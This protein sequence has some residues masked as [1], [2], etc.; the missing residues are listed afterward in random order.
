MQR[1]LSVAVKQ[2]T[3]KLSAWS[4]LK[5]KGLKE[6]DGEESNVRSA[7]E[8]FK[9]LKRSEMSCP[10]YSGAGTSCW[11]VSRGFRSWRRGSNGRLRRC[12]AFR[13]GSVVA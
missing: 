13:E 9:A 10:I 2:L 7:Y 12:G 1:R 4:L 8:G 5:R 11:N 6:S 3:L